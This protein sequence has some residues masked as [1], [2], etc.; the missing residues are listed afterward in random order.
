M[1]NEKI[2]EMEKLRDSMFNDGK[3]PYKVNEINWAQFKDAVR[4]FNK[5]KNALYIGLK[6]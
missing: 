2:K 5:K 4:T 6:K 3:V 1:R